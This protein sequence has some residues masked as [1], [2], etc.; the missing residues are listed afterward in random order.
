M[1]KTSDSGHE[2]WIRSAIL[3]GSVFDIALVR[4]L[5]KKGVIT[6]EEILAEMRTVQAHHP[7]EDMAL[8]GYT[9]DDCRSDTELGWHAGGSRATRLLAELAGI[10]AETSVL[11]VGSALGGSARQLAE[12]YGCSVTGLDAD[13]LRVFESVKRTK[14]RRL[15]NH[16]T[17]MLGNAFKMPFGDEAFDVVWRQCAPITPFNEERL[18]AEC[19]RVLKKNGVFVCQQGMRTEALSEEDTRNA[20]ELQ[21]RSLLDEY[22][23]LLEKAGLTIEKVDTEAP[24]RYDMDFC[25][26]RGHAKRLKLYQERKLIAAIF[27]A[28]K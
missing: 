13:F 21:R 26:T 14:A 5:A 6:Q 16:A 18:L 3:G 24:T 28:R 22:R 10:S 12:V 19:V 9:E 7:Q 2:D 27:V 20:P 23:F 11:D 25:E 17:F 8:A 1:A 15:D 4:L